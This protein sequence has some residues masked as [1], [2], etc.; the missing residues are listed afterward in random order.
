MHCINRL[1]KTKSEF[2]LTREIKKQKVECEGNQM[3]HR[4]NPSTSH[5][6]PKVAESSSVNRFV[7]EIEIQFSKAKVKRNRV[8]IS[9]PFPMR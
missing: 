3:P 9:K 5:T 6:L 4:R 2:K 8:A 7:N 1:R